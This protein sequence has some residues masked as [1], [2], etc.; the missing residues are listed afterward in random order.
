[1][2]QYFWWYDLLSLRFVGINVVAD[3]R[4]P[5]RSQSVSTMRTVHESSNQCCH[6]PK[7]TAAATSQK[8]SSN[9]NANLLFWQWQ[10]RLS[11]VLIR[12]ERFVLSIARGSQ[13]TPTQS[14]S[15][16]TA[17]LTHQ[18][19]FYQN[20]MNNEMMKK[21][22]HADGFIAALDQSGGSSTW[23]QPSCSWVLTV[24]D[25]YVPTN[26]SLPYLDSTQCSL[27]LRYQ[28]RRIW[29]REAIDVWRCSQYED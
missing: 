17:T 25:M 16:T 15:I 27:S 18:L 1:M 9:E 19:P 20:I 8:L 10:R 23:L 22:C 2:I 13:W 6:D 3:A 26:I 28:G 24:E 4:I 5:S 14:H 7:A 11:T 12:N 29:S 21:I